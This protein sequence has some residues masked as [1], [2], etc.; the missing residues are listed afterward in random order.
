LSSS[1]SG[2]HHHRGFCE[3]E[4]E[5]IAGPRCENVMGYSGHRITVEE[6]QGCGTLQCLVRKFERQESGVDDK[7]G[8]WEVDSDW[9]LS[10]LS[11]YMP[12]R[13]IDCPTVFPPRY[14]EDRPWAENCMWQEDE[15][16]Q[17]AMPFHPGCLE[18]WKR[19]SLK[20]TDKMDVEVLA[21]W[22]TLNASYDKFHGFPR[23]PAVKRGEAQEWN[24]NIGDEFLAAN[25][26]FIPGYEKVLE[27]VRTSCQTWANQETQTA[28]PTKTTDIIQS[29]K[30]Q[31]HHSLQ[32]PRT[33]N[34]TLDI[35]SVLPTEIWYQIFTHLSAVEVAY[36]Q[37]ASRSFHKLP[38]SY[39][40]HHLLRERPYLWELWCQQ[41][42]SRWTGTTATALKAFQK[43]CD[44]ENEEIELV[45][46]VLSED[47]YIEARDT[48][49]Q[50]WDEN[51][52]ERRPLEAKS[53]VMVGEDEIDYARLAIELE[54]RL[55]KGQLKGLRN[56]ARIWKDC[57]TILDE[58]E[59]LKKDGKITAEGK[60]AGKWVFD[61]A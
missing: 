31:Q 43:Q 2:H 49:K 40:R 9:Y 35:F 51:R 38:Q 1:K 39:I 27:G 55:E 16:E 8:D 30:S 48:Y 4:W 26:C 21:N 13:D 58:I 41:P 12:S 45:L 25:P 6:M 28:P 34:K 44:V 17:Y 23:D 32:Q 36:L 52:L 24:H 57:E 60:I 20:L 50:Y 46:E 29:G 15:R 5:H 61:D 3:N 42:Y 14:G 47:G 37:R 59:E 53:V 19:A 33:M 18:V 10:G 11:D 56:R 22:W 7:D 54:E